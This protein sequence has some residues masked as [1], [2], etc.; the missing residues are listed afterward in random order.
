MDGWRDEW[1]EG[2]MEGGRKEGRE[3]VLY[4]NNDDLF[5]QTKTES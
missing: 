4:G 5:G 3:L 2:G 1:M